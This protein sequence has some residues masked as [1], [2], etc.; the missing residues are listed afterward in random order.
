MMVMVV[1]SVQTYQGKERIYHNGNHR[2]TLETLEYQ[3]IDVASLVS[4]NH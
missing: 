4:Q 2:K 3:A 1:M